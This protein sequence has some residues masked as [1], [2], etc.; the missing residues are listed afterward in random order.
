MNH[1]LT[2]RLAAGFLA[3]L[4]FALASCSEKAGES[5]NPAGGNPSSGI[6]DA[7]AEILPETEYDPFSEL[8]ADKYD[9]RSFRLLAREAYLYELWTE[10]MTGDVFNDAVY[11]RNTL[12][13]ARYDVKIDPIPIAG[14]WGDRDSFLTTVRASVQANDGAYDLIDGYAATIG[15]GFSSG[16]YLNMREVPN[17]QLE[18]SW[19]SALLRDELTVNG[20]LF[21]ITGDIAVNMWE[22]MQVLFFNKKLAADY[23]I[24]S[25]YDAVRDGSWTFDRYLSMIE[26]HSV[27]LDGDGKM[28]VD[29]SYGAVYYDALTFDNLHNAFGVRYTKRDA[30]GNIELDLYNDQV[31]A[32]SELASALAFDNPDVWYEN[33]GVGDSRE[34]ARKIF[35]ESR[36]L[37]YASVLE[38]AIIMR[39]MD[40]DFGILPY[41]KWNEAQTAYYTTSRDGRSMF[42]IPIDVPNAAF[43]GLITEAMCIEGSRTVIPVYYDKVLK[44]K[45]ARDEESASMLDT[46]RA[47]LVLDFAAEYAVQAERC[48]FIVRDVIEQHTNI[49]SLFKSK[50]KIYNKAF[51]KFLAA[52]YD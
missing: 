1:K 36:G 6:P 51:E 33:K 17:L 25:P 45:T 38:D 15:N 21:A 8:P 18:K 39:D 50:E 22:Q 2:S 4:M 44:G 9:G 37:F 24:G 3:C 28:T 27:D 11:D 10:E 30:E 20:R 47:G 52:Y 35:S 42:A 5:E 19:W 40:A 12:V 29:D 48:G 16:L 14:E 43:S 32:I 23:D 49:A 31:V 26:G 46:I 7:A 34:P 13:E 41:P